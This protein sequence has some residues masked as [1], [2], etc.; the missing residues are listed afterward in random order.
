V[1]TSRPTRIL[2]NAP[3]GAGRTASEIRISANQ[4][5][6]GHSA[7]KKPKTQGR[8]RHARPVPQG[9]A[10]QRLNFRWCGV[11]RAQ[12]LKLRAALLEHGWNEPIIRS[13]LT[14]IDPEAPT[15]FQHLQVYRPP[16]VY[17]SPYCRPRDAHRT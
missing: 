3:R 15:I 8:S 2:P 11:G 1:W 13:L 5:R 17:V 4:H 10:R 16:T 6:P 7:H 14:G 9:P 12:S